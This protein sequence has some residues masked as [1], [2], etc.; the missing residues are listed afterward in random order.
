MSNDEKPNRIQKLSDKQFVLVI[1]VLGAIMIAIATYLIDGIFVDFGLPY[2]ENLHTLIIEIGIGVIITLLIYSFSTQQQNKLKRLVAEIKNLEDIQQKRIIE[3]DELKNQRKEKAMGKIEII[4]TQ[5]W[6]ETK[7][8][9]AVLSKYY[10]DGLPEGWDGQDIS[11]QEISEKWIGMLKRQV[12]RLGEDLR[13]WTL[14][15]YDLL[16]PKLLSALQN[17]Y[18]IATREYYLDHDQPQWDLMDCGSNIDWLESILPEYFNHPKDQ[19]GTIGGN[20]KIKH[21]SE[22]K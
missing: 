11:E 6:S 20:R 7:Y 16:D 21:K 4:L 10:G 3:E 8:H 12:I 19:I 22:E 1:L 9:E 5:L 15:S 14:T 2:P 17:V 18:S 13:N